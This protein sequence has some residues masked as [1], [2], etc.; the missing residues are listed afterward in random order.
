[1]CKKKKYRSNPLN[2]LYHKKLEILKIYN[3]LNIFCGLQVD[4]NQF[5]HDYGRSFIYLCYSVLITNSYIEIK[6]T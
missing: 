4:T 3:A 1:M 6:D 2:I 5:S